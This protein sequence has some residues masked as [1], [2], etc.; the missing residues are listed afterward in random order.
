M[1]FQDNVL[2][3]YLRNV[4][5]VSGTACGGKSSVSKEL[6]RLYGLKVYDIDR[7]FQAHQALSD[8]N[9]QPSMNRVFRNADEFFGRTVEDYKNW[10][11]GNTREQLEFVLLDLIRLSRNAL[12]ICDCHLT[13]E[14]ASRLTDPSRVIFLINETD[15]IIE[16]YCARPDHQD[17]GEFIESASDPEN[18]KRICNETLC[19]LSR[20][21]IA[22]IK[23]S[24]FLYV[25]R[26]HDLTIQDTAAIAAEHFGLVHIYP[27]EKDTPLAEQLT[28]FVMNCSWL[29]VREHITELLRSWSFGENETMFAAV[30]D[31]RIVG[32]AALMMTDYYP[33]PEIYPYVTCIFVSE[34]A[35]GHSIS[36]QLIAHANEYAKKMGFTRTYIPTDI[37]GLY[38]HYGYRYLRDIVNYG[39]GTDRLYAKEL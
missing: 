31:N 39:G 16:S 2:K 29:D 4:Y 24:G 10:L 19:E 38:E 5:F 23:N 1:I 6:G 17:F 7:E 36:G 3:E 13:A 34:E 20:Q 15:N 32:M 27:V 33:L 9:H 37:A 14:E 35:R 21:R 25:Q 22:E 11:I 12:V 30:K 28:E 8:K 18:A 26:C